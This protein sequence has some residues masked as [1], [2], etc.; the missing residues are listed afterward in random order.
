[1]PVLDQVLFDQE[2]GPYLVVQV[3][4]LE[5]LEVRDGGADVSDRHRAYGTA[6]VVRAER[7][8]VEVGEI[9]DLA[10]FEQTAGLGEVG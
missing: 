7:D 10:T 5:E 2:T 1:M 8:V 6:D 4:E 9:G 3:M